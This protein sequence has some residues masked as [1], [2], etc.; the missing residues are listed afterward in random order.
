VLRRSVSELEQSLNQVL[1]KVQQ[2]DLTQMEDAEVVQLRLDLDTLIESAG[3]RKNDVLEGITEQLRNIVVEPDESGVLITR[4]DMAEVAE[5]ELLG[6]RERVETDLDLAQLGMAVEVI[7][8]EFQATIRGV[9]DYLRE[10]KA[11]ADVNQRLEPI[12]N[13]IQVNFNHLD[14]YLSLF[15]PLHRRLRRTKVI[16]KGSEIS[17]FLTELFTLRLERHNVTLRATP[18]FNSH[19]FT[20]YPST[21]YPVFVN[22]VDNAIYWLQDRDGPRAI[23]LDSQGDTMSVTDTGRGIAVRDRQAIFESGFTRKPGGRGLGLYISREAFRREGYD[24][25][26]D[27]PDRLYGAKFLIAPT[28]EDGE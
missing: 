2:T 13:G 23:R 25:L 3:R 28:A 5:E 26:L 9:R 17:K 7:D 18:A 8:H 16:V 22:L 10:L 15:T 12:Y 11:W 20:S 4:L 6:L 24:L 21:F 14:G 19:R 27:E 1:E